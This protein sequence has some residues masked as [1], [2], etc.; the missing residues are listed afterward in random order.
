VRGDD[1]KTAVD[2]VCPIQLKQFT[3]QP[4]VY[5][6]QGCFG[7]NLFEY[8]ERINGGFDIH[9]IA[10]NDVELQRPLCVRHVLVTFWP[11]NPD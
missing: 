4:S 2:P 11:I 8:A 1:A 7:R 5:R 6:Q 9:K 10:M 3:S